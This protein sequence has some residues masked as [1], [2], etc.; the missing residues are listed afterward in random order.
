MKGIVEFCNA[1]SRVNY[2]VNQ[3]IVKFATRSGDS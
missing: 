2:H 3:N 1:A